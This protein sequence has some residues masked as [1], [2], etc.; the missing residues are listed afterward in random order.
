MFEAAATFW[1]AVPLTATDELSEE[2]PAEEVVELAALEA[3]L[4]MTEEEEMLRETELDADV[5]A[6]TDELVEVAFAAAPFEIHLAPRMPPFPYT[7][8]PT[9]CFM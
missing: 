2:D 4:E 7:G 8:F 9:A 1:L 3:E 5:E 6:T